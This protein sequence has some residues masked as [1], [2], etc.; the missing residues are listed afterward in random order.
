MLFLMTAFIG[1]VLY[2]AISHLTN[3]LINQKIDYIVETQSLNA[4]EFLWTHQSEKLYEIPK[5]IVKDPHILGVRIIDTSIGMPIE[6]TSAGIPFPDN[7][8]YPH[9][10]KKKILHLTRDKQVQEL[11][12]FDIYVDRVG[13]KNNILLTAVFI[14][15]SALVAY[16]VIILTLNITLKNALQPIR[17]MTDQLKKVS[18]TYALARPKNVNA[19]EIKLLY[20]AFDKMQLNI[21]EYQSTLILAKEQAED[22]NR[23]KDDF[24]ANMSHEIRTPL[25]AIIGMSDLLME[26]NIS[27]EQKDMIKSIHTSGDLLLNIINDIIDI[28]KIE[29]EKLVLENIEFDLIDLVEET[30]DMF[31]FLARDKGLE[32]IVDV[33]DGLLNHVIGDPVRIKQIITNLI[34][35][36]IKFTETGHISLSIT[37]NIHNKE[38]LDIQFKF[39][40]TGIGISPD[41]HEIIFEKFSQAEEYTTRNFGGTGLGLAI[42]K[43]LVEIMNGQIKVKSSKGQGSD[44]VFNII[45]RNALKDMDKI[46]D[47]PAPEKEELSVLVIEDYEPTSDWF[48]A[49]LK[50]NRISCCTCKNVEDA[51]DIAE[52]DLESFDLF[53][54]NINLSDKINIDFIKEIK[55]KNNAV[56]QGIILIHNAIDNELPDPY[57]D[58]GVDAVLNKPVLEKALIPKIY[59]VVESLK[60][61]ENLSPAAGHSHASKE[62]G[63]STCNRQQYPDA[64]ILAVDDLPMN[65]LVVTRVLKKYGVSVCQAV[66]GVEAVKKVEGTNYDMIFMDCNMPEMDG[67]QA[68][69]AIRSMTC[70][71]KN[72]IP[73]VALTADAMT[74]DR[75]K[76]LKHGMS[77]YINKPFKEKDIKKALERWIESKEG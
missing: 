21:G 35:N 8:Q 73:I 43:E 2:F 23:T 42:V 56:Q 39:C 41:K 18:E 25:N 63:I 52:R 45:L 20:D 3:N 40:D 74:G 53:I 67:F 77:D 17:F 38:F 50:R 70:T 68:T 58:F 66:N 10:I 27:L 33:H 69:K 15:F 76:C 37:A 4:R 6:A 44:F 47:M 12:S 32:V 16:I 29:A 28:S 24:L 13:I 36:A 46:Q 5:S 59:D 26:Y 7:E 1:C 31:Y 57:K 9:V 11:G 49:V 60:R 72:S 75:E 30:V 48:Y 14:L 71:I 22:A 61:G 55:S 62:V 34:G 64:K 65:M 51:L 19:R 54:L